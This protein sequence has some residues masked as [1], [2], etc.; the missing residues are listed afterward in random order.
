VWKCYDLYLWV[1]RYLLSQPSYCVKRKKQK[2][3]LSSQNKKSHG[4]EHTK[5]SPAYFEWGPSWLV[6][7][8]RITGVAQ[9]WLF[10]LF[11][12]CKIKERFVFF[13]YLWI[14]TLSFTSDRL[15][16]SQY[17]YL[18][19]LCKVSEGAAHIGQEAWLTL[20]RSSV[21]HKA[22]T[23]RQ[24]TTNS[25]VNTCEQLPNSPLAR[26]ALDQC[27]TQGEHANNALRLSV[28]NS[29]NSNTYV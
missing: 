21:Y 15:T 22:N 6:N 13:S 4:L 7:C 28:L 17:L 29:S 8:T 1:H 14:T 5:Q 19:S 3:F 9:C 18:L 25:H 26:R 2:L 20:D 16:S 24:T 27:K 23:H 11:Q 12:Q 10:K